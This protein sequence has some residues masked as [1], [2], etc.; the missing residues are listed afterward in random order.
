MSDGSTQESSNFFTAKSEPIGAWLYSLVGC[1]FAP[2]L[3]VIIDALQHG[4]AS[5]NVVFVTASVM[6]VGY[7]ISAEHNLFR[8]FYSLTFIG[9]LLFGSIAAQ[10]EAVT[11]FWN[12]PTF[13]IFTAAM[14]HSAERFWWH[15]VWD[16]PFPDCLWRKAT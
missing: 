16:R 4:R 11:G 8:A 14:L 15:V 2:C 9:S 12:L 6:S 1:V 3:P 10:T 13:A 7:L 5:A